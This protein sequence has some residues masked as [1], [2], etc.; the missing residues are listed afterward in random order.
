MKQYPFDVLTLSETWLKDNRQLLEYVSIPGYNFEFRNRE[1]I[2]GGGVGAYIKESV[3]YIR[4]KD[5]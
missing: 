3:Q 2:R 1:N 4:R 5:F